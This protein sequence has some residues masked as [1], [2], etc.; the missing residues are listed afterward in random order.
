MDEVRDEIDS[1]LD[2]EVIDDNRKILNNAIRDREVTDLIENIKFANHINENKRGLFLRLAELFLKDLSA[3]LFLNQFKL[4]AKY[5][6]TTADEWT[7]FLMDNMVAKYIG[8]HKNIYMKTAA[9]EN[10]T[11]V[12]GKGKK[13]SLSLIDKIESEIKE[14]S[15]QNIIIMRIPG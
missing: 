13:D 10:I 9:E 6:D 14:D 8:R 12:A 11:S 4:S 7:T 2:T 15:K 1:I 5:E 3:N